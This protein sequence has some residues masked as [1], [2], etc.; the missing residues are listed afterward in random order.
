MKTNSTACGVTASV[1][2]TTQQPG[3]NLAAPE[4]VCAVLGIDLGDRH[5]KYC[6]LDVQGTS[7]GDGIVATTPAALRL[8]FSGKGRMRIAVEVGTHSPW[9]SRLLEEL[10]HEVIVANPRKL[11]LITES[12]AKNDHADA[13]LLARLAYAGPDL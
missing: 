3:D 7:I 10:G 13:A 4:S 9:V 5:S 2:G 1:S 6:V 11:R 12:D 8:L